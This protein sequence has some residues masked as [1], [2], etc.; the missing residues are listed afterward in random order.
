MDAARILLVEDEAL[1]A[2]D[3]SRLLAAEGYSV[4]HAHTGEEAVALAASDGFD[5]I[6]MDIN[7]GRGID[8]GEAARRIRDSGGAPVVFLSSHAEPAVIDKT[9]DAG[10]YGYILK[11]TGKTVLLTSVRMALDLARAQRRLAYDEKRWES[12]AYAAPD[13]IFSLNEERIVTWVNR[14]G[15]HGRGVSQA[16]GMSVY[17][18][19]DE[20]SLP[21]VKEAVEGAFADG[22]VREYRARERAIPGRS[23]RSWST[24]IGPVLE[25][26]RVVG[27]T[28]VSREDPGELP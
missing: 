7:L 13:I 12:L 14:P 3:V 23:P 2:L 9:R 4:V 10:G 18:L 22:R 19:V 8:G 16:Y 21:L 27:L 20:A 26:G 24:R 11:G 17:D 6:L 15:S 5:L 28:L 1:I 25:G